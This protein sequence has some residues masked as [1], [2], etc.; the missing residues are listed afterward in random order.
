MPTRWVDEYTKEALRDLD[1][2]GEPRRTRAK[3]AIAKVLRNPLPMSEGGY[4]KPL[5]NK[6]GTNLTGLCKNK[7]CGDGIRVVYA[8]ERRAHR[9]IVIVV[10]VRGDDEVYGQAS[11]RLE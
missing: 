1:K 5:G 11:R 8:L 2:L 4:G 3:K 9:M 10:S 7:L 6:R